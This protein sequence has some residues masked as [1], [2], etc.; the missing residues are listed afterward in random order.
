MQIQKKPVDL[1]SIAPHEDNLYIW[2]GTMFGPVNF[3]LKL[4]S[5]FY[6]KIISQYDLG[7]L[8]LFYIYIILKKKLYIYIYYNLII[9]FFKD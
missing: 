3:I 6:L 9:H 1:I 5:I 2:D 7:K 4:Y 8:I